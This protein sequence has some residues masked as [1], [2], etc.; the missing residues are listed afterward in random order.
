MYYSYLQCNHWKKL[1]EGTGLQGPSCCL[2]SN[3]WKPLI[4]SP[5]LNVVQMKSCWTHAAFCAYLPSLSIMYLRFIHVI[6]CVICVCS[7]MHVYIYVCVCVCVNFSF[8]NRVTGSCK[9][10]AT[11]YPQTIS[12]NG[13]ILGNC[14]TRA[15]AGN[16]RWCCVGRLITC[17]DSC[18]H[19]LNQ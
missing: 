17:T 1:A 6:G 14:N 3:P 5:S 15:E 11:L 18:Y 7:W 16:W 2:P 10:S 12:S 19:H 4:Y 8:W 9:D 13:Y